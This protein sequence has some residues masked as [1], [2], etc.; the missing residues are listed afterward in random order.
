MVL[1]KAYKI[2]GNMHFRNLLEIRM[3]K[4]E[5]TKQPKRI[6]D[7]SGFH[8]VGLI[9]TFPSGVVYQNQTEGIACS[10]AEA[11]GV[12]L[13]L[14]VKPGASEMWAFGQHFHG[15]I[16]P[17]DQDA[18]RIVDRILRRNGH[19]YLMVNQ[20][21]LAE[22]YEA[23]IHVFIDEAEKPLLPLRMAV[24]GFGKCEGILTWSNSD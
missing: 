2:N 23:W 22:S 1:S 8:G 19:T 20:T 15:K 10:H 11:E 6:I 12:F 16:G 3:G 7:L 18:A 9:I 13:P 21:R 4:G 24:S 14:S 17:I 5:M